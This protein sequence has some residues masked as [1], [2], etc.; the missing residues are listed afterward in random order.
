LDALQLGASGIFLE[1][2]PPESLIRAIRLMA[3]GEGWVDEKVIQLLAGSH[4]PRAVPGLWNELT[5]RERHV[6]EGI[7]E[8][9]TNKRIGDKIGASEGTV[10]ATLRRLF[11]KAGVRT[12]S[13]LV[14]AALD[15]A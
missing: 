15:K 11:Q 3:A 1:S 2:H 5:L 13:Q 7:L 14:R 6:L 9:L 8:G 4:A 10:K 12:R